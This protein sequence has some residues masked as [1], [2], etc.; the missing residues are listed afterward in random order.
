LISNHSQSLGAAW[1]A[2]LWKDIGSVIGVELRAL[3]LEGVGENH[4]N[5]LPKIG[6]E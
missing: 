6:L 4:P 1:N 3:W 2:T 5:R